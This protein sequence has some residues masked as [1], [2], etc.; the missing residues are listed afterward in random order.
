MT[1]FETLVFS[2]PQHENA[3]AVS[4]TT[5]L[6]ARYTTDPEKRRAGLI[7]IEA[8]L[9]ALAD[10]I[11]AMPAAPNSGHQLARNEACKDISDI[12]NL[13][14][15]D[16]YERNRTQTG[17]DFYLVLNLKA[18]ELSVKMGRVTA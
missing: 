8:Q 3:K 9:E 17:T 7:V 15:S 16:V 4:H 18:V 1:Q 6:M 10:S 2:T 14:Q 11:W 12:L 5:T 13:I